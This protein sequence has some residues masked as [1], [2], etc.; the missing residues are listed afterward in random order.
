MLAASGG[1]G[2]QKVF[3]ALFGLPA[4]GFRVVDR[5][6][7]DDVSRRR[8]ARRVLAANP[9]PC[10]PLDE[11]DCRFLVVVCVVVVTVV[12]ARHLVNWPGPRCRATTPDS[13]SRYRL[14]AD[15]AQMQHHANADNR[16]D[17]W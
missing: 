10:A 15:R 16:A 2:Q 17:R 11:R 7:P 1:S 13:R 8:G 3:K 5:E 4:V 6:H 9:C 12:S 14:R